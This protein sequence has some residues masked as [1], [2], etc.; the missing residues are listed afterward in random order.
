MTESYLI[1]KDSVNNIG[2]TICEN[3]YNLS[4][5]QWEPSIGYG[6]KKSNNSFDTLVCFNGSKSKT[7]F[8]RFIEIK[9]I[10]IKF[11]K[12]DDVKLWWEKTK[13]K[14]YGKMYIALKTMGKVIEGLNE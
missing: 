7:D 12:D 14:T 8:K 2:K 3:N 11:N 5:H 4:F 13:N 1:L 10:D 9:T 6:F